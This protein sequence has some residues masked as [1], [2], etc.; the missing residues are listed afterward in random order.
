[1]STATQ[2]DDRTAR[3]RIRDAA[4]VCFARDGFST[5][6]RSIAQEAG[7]SVPLITH[8]YKTKDALRQTCDEWVLDRFLELKLLAIH[9][10]DSVKESLADTSS[11]S[12]LTVYIVRS[13]L[14][15]TSSARRFFDRY[16][17][18]LRTIIATARAAGMVNPSVDEEEQL[19]LL[20]TQSIGTL[21]VEFVLHPPEDPT[22][23][24]DQVFTSRNM[25]A[26]MEIY[27]QPLLAPSPAMDT[28][29]TSIKEKP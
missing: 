10:P 12:V 5:P 17:D 23:F 2:P 4:L 13:F 21:M 20:A 27:S 18:Q 25:T 1:M 14:D 15:A 7:V 28:Y 6:L 9:T 24:V 11:A 3:A 22:L 26:Y 16:M 8:H 29:L 19:H